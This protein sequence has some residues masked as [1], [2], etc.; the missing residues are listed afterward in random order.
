MAAP[1]K[2]AKTKDQPDEQAQPGLAGWP[3]DD[4]ASQAAAEA[5][6]AGEAGV[7]WSPPPRIELSA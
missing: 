5:A 2:T 6:A 4:G 1:R 3:D 7:L